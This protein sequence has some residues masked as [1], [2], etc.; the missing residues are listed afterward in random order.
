MQPKLKH[1]NLQRN[2]SNFQLLANEILNLAANNEYIKGLFDE[3]HA[4]LKAGPSVFH[5]FRPQVESEAFVT[6]FGDTDIMSALRNNELYLSATPQAYR[7]LQSEMDIIA[8]IRD[9][10]AKLYHPS[11]RVSKKGSRMFPPSVGLMGKGWPRDDTI[12]GL[13]VPANAQVGCFNEDA[14]A[15]ESQPWVDALLGK[16]KEME[17][18]YGVVFAN[19]TR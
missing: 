5:Q 6:V 2:N 17:A 3:R 8:V 18:F 19:G 12:C 9:A 10:E 11:R 15:D 4:D 13:K 7:A 1:H 14:D 16:R